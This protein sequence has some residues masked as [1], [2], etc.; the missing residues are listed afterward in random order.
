MWNRCQLPRGSF[1]ERIEKPDVRPDR[2]YRAGH[3]IRQKNPPAIRAHR[4]N[5]HG[6]LRL[7]RLLFARIG[8]TYMACNAAARLRR[9]RG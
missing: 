8:T 1:L 6:D 9:H 4:C 3:R 5:L 7:L 2:R